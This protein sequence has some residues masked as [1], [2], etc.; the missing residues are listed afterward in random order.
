MRDVPP[1]GLPHLVLFVLLSFAVARLTRLV[2]KD[3][4][5]ELPRKH[6]VE[7]L[8]DPVREKKGDHD[9]IQYVQ[10]HGWVTY[11]REKIAY[12]ITCPY[13]VGAYTTAIMLLGY[14]IW[15]GV[16]V[17]PVLWWFAVWMAAIAILEYT[18]GDSKSK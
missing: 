7:W 13:C 2:Y 14:R 4:I 12:L 9:T 6:F 5:F 1:F 11:L 16:L 8:Q 17:A 3:T 10:R 18:D 15:V